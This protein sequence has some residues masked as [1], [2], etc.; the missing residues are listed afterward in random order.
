LLARVALA[1]TIAEAVDA[2]EALPH[3]QSCRQIVAAGENWFELAGS[4]ERAEAVVSAAQAKH[5]VADPHFEKASATF[6]HCRM[7]WEEA[8]TLQNWG[9]AL[10]SAGEPARAIEKLDAAIEIYRSHGTGKPFVEYVM[11][12]KMRAQA[13]TSNHAEVSSAYRFDSAGCGG[14]CA[15][16]SPFGRAVQVKWLAF[17]KSWSGLAQVR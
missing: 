7:P 8:N 1:V 5:A 15:S 14:E 2:P 9:R 6:Q 10:L 16:A 17:P 11:V 3:L 12:D 4:V 13:S